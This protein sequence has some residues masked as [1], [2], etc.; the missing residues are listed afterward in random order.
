VV[1]H[2]LIAVQTFVKDADYP[3]GN[4]A[5]QDDGGTLKATFKYEL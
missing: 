4:A 1:G 5:V 2:V 3:S